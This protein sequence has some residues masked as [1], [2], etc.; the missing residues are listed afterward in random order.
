ME[1]KGN[2][3]FGELHILDRHLHACCYERGVLLPVNSSTS[4]KCFSFCKAVFSGFSEPFQLYFHPTPH[5]S[6]SLP[7]APLCTVNQDSLH[8]DWLQRLTTS[9]LTLEWLSYSC[10]CIMN[11]FLMCVQQDS[12]ELSRSTLTTERETRGL[13]IG[14]VGICS[15]DCLIQSFC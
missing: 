9:H 14:I 8:S 15:L 12:E 5:R 11:M 13:L 2:E 3:V 7:S 10:I 4:A 1:Q 6:P